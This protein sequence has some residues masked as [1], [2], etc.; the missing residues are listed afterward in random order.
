MVHLL[1]GITFAVLSI[2]LIQCE[3]AVTGEARPPQDPYINPL[4]PFCVTDCV[5]GVCNVCGN[6]GM[7]SGCDLVYPIAKGMLKVQASLT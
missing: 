3:A 5:D 7:D 2:M 4:N 1:V 6:V